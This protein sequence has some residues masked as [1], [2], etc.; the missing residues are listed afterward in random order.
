MARG[1]DALTRED[2]RYEEIFSVEKETQDA[3]HILI[4]DPYPTFATLRAQSP[5]YFGS[6]VEKLTGHPD[7][8]YTRGRPHCTTLSFDACSKALLQNTLYSSL[9]YHEQPV[10]MDSIGHTILTMVGDEH[11]RY[12]TSVQPM[13][14]REQAMG[15]WREKWIEP[16]VST[17]I[18]DF[19]SKGEADLALQLCARLPMHTVTAAYGLSSDEAIAFR[20]S[21]IGSMLPTF[22]PEQRAAASTRVRTVLLGAV[23]ERRRERRDDLISRLIDAPHKSPQGEATHLDDE[24]ILSFSRLLLLAGGGTTFRQLGIT[25]FALLSNREQLEALRADR[26]LMHGAIQESLRWNC[27]DPLFYRLATRDSVLEGV[28]IPEGTIV[29]VCLGAGNRDPQRW[30]NPDRYDLHRPLQRHVG[31]AGGPH[32]CLGRFVAEA[33]MTAAITALLDRLPK[34]RLD[35]RSEPTRIIGGMQARGVNHLRVR[36]D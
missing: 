31:F 24:A 35:D 28:E 6:I 17:L 1:G 29:D 9:L 33:E 32:T 16:F 27:T 11:A 12:R 20:E 14:A 7:S 4:D 25:L 30:E 21:L 5:V 10:I 15:W 13:M 34:L 19:E 22:T 36:F 3:G 26:A 8:Q 18:D 23:A 2:K